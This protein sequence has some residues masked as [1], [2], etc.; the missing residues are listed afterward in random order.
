MAADENSVSYRKAKKIIDAVFDSVADDIASGES[1][2]VP[3][4]GS[5]CIKER[6][7][8]QIKDINTGEYITIPTK[9]KIKYSPNKWIITRINK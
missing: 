9:K 8:Y 4:L 1:V 5:F 3:K 6:K 2:T 7:E